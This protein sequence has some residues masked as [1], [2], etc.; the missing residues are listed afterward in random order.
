MDA[1]VGTYSCEWTEVV[2]NPERQ[3]M[4]RQFVNTVSTSGDAHVKQQLNPRRKRRM[5]ELW[6]PKSSAR[7]AN[8]YGDIF[9]RFVYVV[10]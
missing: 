9:L 2:R 8:W 3:K 7:E 10:S 1:L 6:A 4:F 5:N